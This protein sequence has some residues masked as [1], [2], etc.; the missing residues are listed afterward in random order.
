[1]T[2]A[3]RLSVVATIYDTL[4]VPGGRMGPPEVR[5]LW[6]ARAQL[7]ATLAGQVQ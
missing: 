1:M 7:H 6:I 4:V 3:Q 5:A 2:R